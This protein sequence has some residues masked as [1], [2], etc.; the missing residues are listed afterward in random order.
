MSKRYQ[1]AQRLGAW[2]VRWQN[3][4]S[5]KVW[6]FSLA[7]SPYLPLHRWDPWGC[8]IILKNKTFA[9]SICDPRV[10]HLRWW[11][12]LAGYSGLLQA[13]YLQFLYFINQYGMPEN[14][15]VGSQTTRTDRAYDLLWLKGDLEQ[16]MDFF[17]TLFSTP[18]KL[19]G[20]PQW[21]PHEAVLGVFE[22]YFS[23]DID[24]LMKSTVVFIKD[25]ANTQIL[26]HSIVILLL[27]PL[28]YLLHSLK[29]IET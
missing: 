8:P 13:K 14:S 24:K 10:L 6:R 3:G 29:H 19:W 4:H 16:C 23:F 11:K 27:H 2:R 20:C 25:P 15:G 12:R 9:Y 28:Q 21:G 5:N 7:F 17:K 18:A 1:A 26:F 22:R